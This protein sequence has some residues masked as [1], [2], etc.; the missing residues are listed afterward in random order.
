MARAGA[1]AIV[2]VVVAV[3]T[4]GILGCSD[5]SGGG[6]AES[7][8][9]PE[10]GPPVK[11][12]PVEI[13]VVYSEGVSGIDLPGIRR[14][15][16]AAVEYVNTELGGF[17][18][19]PGEVVA[20][21]DRSD[22]AADNACAQEFIDNDVVAIAGA[23]V[24]WGDNG[25]G[26]VGAEGIPYVGLPVSNAEF[27]APTS[28]PFDGGPVSGFPAL[29]KYFAEDVGIESAVVLA[30]D[31]GAAELA[32]DA[33]IADPLE[34]RGVT[35]VKLVTE[36]VNAADFS[37]AVVAATEDDPDV[38]FVLFADAECRRIFDTARQLGSEATLTGLFSCAPSAGNESDAEGG[39][40]SSGTVFYDQ[41]NED[42]AAYQAAMQRYGDDD[43][44]GVSATAFSQV[45]TLRTVIEQIGVPNLSR[46]ALLSTLDDAD[47]I[48]VFMATKLDKDRAA[49]L[50][51]IPTHV[52]NPDARII[53]VQD[54]ELVD[55]GG[56][57]VDGFTG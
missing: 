39:V 15:A 24:V 33:L 7:T 28:Y 5:D 43:I 10:T 48:P 3:G 52:Y 4:M 55:V 47:G 53:A 16:E 40:F 54:G 2:G 30:P 22:P 21:N 41:S 11:G 20:C 13:G 50:A 18:G 44:S 35:D 36:Q 42:A 29:A 19:H 8:P 27:V 45:M 32:A 46:A 26:I 38:V 34:E 6:S 23:S 49:S 57:W 56:G 12:A 37:S 25:L 17:D 51:G 1:L 9:P 31:I 14:G